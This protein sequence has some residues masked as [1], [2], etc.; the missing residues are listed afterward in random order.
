[1][2]ELTILPLAFFVA[3]VIAVRRVEGTWV[4][5]CAFFG[6]YWSAF[7]AGTYVLVPSFELLTSGVTWIVVCYAALIVGAQLASRP[8]IRPS[9]RTWSDQPDDDDDELRILRPMVCVCALLALASV[10]ILVKAAGV[11]FGELDTLKG[12][13]RV[14][15]YYTSNRYNDPDFR[16]PALG[17]ALYSFAYLGSLLGGRLFFL[18]TTIRRRMLGFAPL[19]MAGFLATL[20]TTRAL[21]LLSMLLWATGYVVSYVARGNLHRELVSVKNLSFF[22][23]FVVV[24]LV[25]FVG[26]QLVR[27]GGA[28]NVAKNE[29][30][31][32]IATSFLGS[33]SSFTMWFDKTS[34]GQLRNYGWGARTL[35]GPLRWLLPGFHRSSIATFEPI[36]VGT[37]SSLGEDTTVATLFRELIYDFTLP[38]SI[39]CLIGIG[40]YGARSFVLSLVGGLRRSAALASYYFLVLYSMMGFVYKF[41]TLIA[42]MLGFW[43]YCAYAGSRRY[44]SLRSRQAAH[45]G[46]GT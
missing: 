29:I 40:Y 32:S 9:R 14:A 12:F 3:V 6:A 16:E 27:A 4:G 44:R 22:M 36:I 31:R 39:L 38:G 5:P 33:T 2:T 15:V 21:V 28:A 20:M 43:A 7:L 45:D 35:S 46:G 25:L 42:V 10:P 11:R 18:S 1:M 41:T 8:G 23:L 26:G 24:A 34:G 30:Y 13:L 37:G 17:I 19:A